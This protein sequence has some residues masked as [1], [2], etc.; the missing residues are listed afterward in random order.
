MRRKE[1]KVKYL[2]FDHGQEN[3]AEIEKNLKPYDLVTR[4]N[5]GEFLLANDQS[6]NNLEIRLDRI[7]HFS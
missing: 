2:V 5:Q 3:N 1:I 4:K 6:G 7:I